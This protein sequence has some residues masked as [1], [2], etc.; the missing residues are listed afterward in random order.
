M[1]SSSGSGSRNSDPGGRQASGSK[2]GA[3]S[4]SAEQAVA[5]GARLASRGS[6]AVKAKDDGMSEA[7]RALAQSSNP[8]AAAAEAT[9]SRKRVSQANLSCKDKKDLEAAGVVNVSQVKEKLK[10]ASNQPVHAFMFD[11]NT[12]LT[13][14]SIFL[15]ET[16]SNTSGNEGQPRPSTSRVQGASKAHDTPSKDTGRSKDVSPSSQ[17]QSQ[18]SQ[19]QNDYIFSAAGILLAN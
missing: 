15:Q 6:V 19:V 18:L 16:S 11:C 1:P 5:R 4:T 10:K 7:A 13:H 9:K 2:K 12:C 3:N 8:G 14:H 17:S